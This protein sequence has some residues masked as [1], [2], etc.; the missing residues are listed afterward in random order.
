MGQIDSEALFIRNIH[1]EL[2]E[3][4]KDFPKQFKFQQ[5][6]REGSR[7]HDTKLQSR[8]KTSLWI[9]SE[10]RLL[11]SKQPS[12]SK[13]HPDLEKQQNVKNIFELFSGLKLLSSCVT[14]NEILNLLIPCFSIPKWKSLKLLLKII[15]RSKWLQT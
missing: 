6:C 3:Q 7:I 14:L 10:Q 9:S 8:P 13:G 15:L 12:Q 4:T 11:F 1:L 5:L 2:N